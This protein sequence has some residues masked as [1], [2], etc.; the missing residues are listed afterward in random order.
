VAAPAVGE[1]LNTGAVESANV[2]TAESLV[3]M[4]ELSRQFE[5]NVNLMRTVDENAAAGSQLIRRG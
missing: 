2:N 4:I 5:L 3:K 1:V